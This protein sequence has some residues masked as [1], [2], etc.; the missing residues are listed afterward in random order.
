MWSGSAGTPRSLWQR[1]TS[2]LCLRIRFYGEAAF[3]AEQ[4]LLQQRGDFDSPTIVSQ[5][6]FSRFY[7]FKSQLE[8]RSLSSTKCNLAFIPDLP[9]GK[10]RDAG[11][12][13]T[14]ALCPSRRY[15]NC[16]SGTFPA[17][18]APGACWKLDFFPLMK[19]EVKH[20]ATA[21]NTACRLELTRGHV[22]AAQWQLGLS[23]CSGSRQAARKI[24][25]SRPIRDSAWR[26]LLSSRINST[27]DTSQYLG[28]D[29]PAALLPPTV[30]LPLDYLHVTYNKK[31]HAFL[32]IV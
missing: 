6:T 10:H 21:V 27:W 11:T 13:G 32:P 3:P 17:P 5:V 18:A 15:S 8:S 24:K 12:A 23:Q 2:W 25:V 29:C 16:S 30:F 14:P 7:G 1:A 4:I 9:Q 26:V 31:H 22:R 20:L 28:M 19:T